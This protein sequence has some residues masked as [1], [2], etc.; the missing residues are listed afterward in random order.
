MKIQVLSPGQ[1]GY[2]ESLTNISSVPKQLFYIGQVPSDIFKLPAVAI[3]G[4]RKVSSYGLRITEELAGGLA[5]HG[6]VIVSGLALGVDAIAHR[7]A[8]EA[9]GL[10]VAVLPCGLDQIYPAANRQLSLQIIERRGCIIS[11]Y[12]EQ[13]EPYQSNFVARNRI[14][15]G[16]SKV[17]VITEAAEKSG[18]LHTAKFA[19]EQGKDVGAV[20]GSIYNPT[21]AGTNNLI[22]SGATPI[23]SVSDVL[24]MLG[25]TNKPKI[26]PE[27]IAANEE[28][29]I[30]MTLINEGVNDS[31]ALMIDSGL[32]AAI[33]N[34]TLTML[35]IKGKIKVSSG[36]WYLI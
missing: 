31:E 35:E 33:F 5:A 17:I 4:S 21:S 36:Q 8:I 22:K 6:I 1:K 29:H 20:P 10:T 32:E 15:A 13:T 34:Q 12:S 16:L 26:R 14:V 30:I 3:V 7:T 18:S 11:E 28:E 24:Q 2:P 9:G 23:T 25:L 19:L 27:I